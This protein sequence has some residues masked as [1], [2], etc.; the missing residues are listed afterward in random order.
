MNKEKKKLEEQIDLLYRKYEHA[1]SLKEARLI[2]ISLITLYQFYV[3][4]FAEEYINFAKLQRINPYFNEKVLQDQKHKLNLF[5]QNFI[6]NKHFHHSFLEKIFNY[7]KDIENNTEDSSQVSY[8]PPK[9]LGEILLTYYEIY[10]QESLKIYHNMLKE[11]RIISISQH[12]D[13]EIKGMT[14][15]DYYHNTFF[16]SHSGLS[17]GIESVGALVHEIGHIEDVMSIFQNKRLNYFEKSIYQEVNS[18]YREKELYNFLYK[19]KTYSKEVKEI[20]RK[21]LKQM[22]KEIFSILLLSE[23]PD[24]YLINN[25]YRNLNQ[26]KINN[27]YSNS[28]LNVFQFKESILNNLD[29]FNTLQY[30]YGQILSSYFLEHKDAYLYFKEKKFDL[31]DKKVFNELDITSSKIIKVLEKSIKKQ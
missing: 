5:H 14:I 1:K 27:L 13:I 17:N 31:F 22:L 4:I 6:Q 24:T 20:Q 3:S 7:L 26:N 8:H 29:L 19:N 16:I 18:L 21:N 25:K 30:G 10:S 2:Y 11:H 9:E 12:Q 15:F 28:N 23:L